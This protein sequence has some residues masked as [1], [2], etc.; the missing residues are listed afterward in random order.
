MIS[1]GLVFRDGGYLSQEFTLRL[2]LLKKQ[3]NLSSE[4][5]IIFN[6]AF[7][8]GQNVNFPIKAFIR[9]LSVIRKIYGPHLCSWLFIALL[10]LLEDTNNR[11]IYPQNL[12]KTLERLRSGLKL[13]QDVYYRLENNFLLFDSEQ[14]SN[15]TNNSKYTYFYSFSELDEVEQ[16]LKNA[17]QT[18]ELPNNSSAEDVHRQY[19]KLIFKYHPDR[20]SEHQRQNPAM[21]KE[22]KEK[23]E[24][25]YSAYHLICEHQNKKI[26]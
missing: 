21:I 14:K 1:A 8:E 6:K 25:I 16:K 20:L 2:N 24:A 22:A 12:L 5:E 18:L 17:Y 19:R 26:G 11:H 3:I 10:K 4:Q 15:F 7:Q 23:I 13:K 9:Y